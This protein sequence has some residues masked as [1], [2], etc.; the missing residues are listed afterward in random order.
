MYL[1]NRPN[2]Y[3]YMHSRQY[4]IDYTMYTVYTLIPKILRSKDIT[5]PMHAT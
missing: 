4:Y 3:Q 5:L 2:S 1:L